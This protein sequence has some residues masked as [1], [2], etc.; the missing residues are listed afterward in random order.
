M[1][2]HFSKRYILAVMNKANQLLK[3][4]C[5]NISIK[6]WEVRYVLEAKREIDN[7]HKSSTKGHH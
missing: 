6:D 5:H 1:K 2:E 3:K 7:E 4:E